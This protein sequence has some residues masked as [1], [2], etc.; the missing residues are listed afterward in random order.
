MQ[1]VRMV[2]GRTAVPL[3]SLVVWGALVLILGVVDTSYYFGLTCIL[4]N[5]KPFRIIFKRANLSDQCTSHRKL[6][7]H[8]GLHLHTL[9]CH[10]SSEI[11]HCYYIFIFFFTKVAIFSI[12]IPATM[13]TKTYNN[14]NNNYITILTK[15]VLYP[16]G[17]NHRYKCR[18]FYIIA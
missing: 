7:L 1:N 10:W 18:H 12:N 8:S 11:S 6:H 2:G 3:R 17:L 16:K 4:L 5:F 13:R 14:I 15:Q 9:Q